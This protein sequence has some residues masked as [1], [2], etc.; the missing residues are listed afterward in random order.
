MDS[1]Y[2]MGGCPDREVGVAT[3]AC[4]EFN[5]KLR[6]WRNVAGMNEVR[7][8]AASA[9]FQ[10]KIFVSG[11][12]NDGGMT[13]TVEAYEHVAD[14]WTHMPG[15]IQRRDSHVSV[16][17]KNKLIRKLDWFVYF[18]VLCRTNFLDFFYNKN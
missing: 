16:A 11:G 13:N 9:V 18:K 8:N 2:I 1:F 12:L 10:G 4:A 7:M 3:N 14:A 15:I 6:A 5:S 17:V